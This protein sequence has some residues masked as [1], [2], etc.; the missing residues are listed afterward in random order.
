MTI[1]FL[2]GLAIFL[3]TTYIAASL[4]YRLAFHLASK[5]GQGLN[6][7]VTESLHWIG[8]GYT[9]PE[10]ESTSDQKRS[11]DDINPEERIREVKTEEGSGDEWAAV[12]HTSGGKAEEK[13]PLLGPSQQGPTPEGPA[14]LG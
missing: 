3:T 6:A 4:A 1:S 9:P 10:P 5:D 8:V 14:I 12:D 11:V 7:W 2:F 13:D